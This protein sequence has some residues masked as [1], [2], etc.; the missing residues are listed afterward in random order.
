M[1]PVATTTEILLDCDN[2]CCVC[3]DPRAAPLRVHRI[4]GKRSNRAMTNLAVLCPRC[5]ADAHIKGRTGRGLGPDLVR[6]HTI[7]WVASVQENRLR[8]PWKE[9]MSWS[10]PKGSPDAVTRIRSEP[11]SVS[12][13]WRTSYGTRIARKHHGHLRILVFREGELEPFQEVADITDHTRSWWHREGY[14]I[15]DTGTFTVE[16][17]ANTDWWWV[18]IERLQQ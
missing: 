12:G 17:H 3:H 16:I 7:D 9:L 14:R 5:H 13:P 11:F 8:S 1:S 2:T 15:K 10:V 18:R 6:R 4:D